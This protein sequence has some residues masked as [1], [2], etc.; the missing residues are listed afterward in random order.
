M[1]R[2]KKKQE[3]L[4]QSAKKLNSESTKNT[5][6]EPVDETDTSSN[7]NKDGID[8]D[9]DAPQKEKVKIFGIGRGKSARGAPKQKK[10]SPGELRIQKDIA[11]LD[12][13]KVAVVTFP[14][15]N[16]LT[17]FDVR[18]TADTGLWKGATYHF[19]FKIPPLYPHEPPKVQCMTK[20]YHPN[21]D[22]EGNVCLNILRE[23]WKPVLDINAVIY[24]LIYLFYEPNP[25]DPLNREAAEQFRTNPKQFERIVSRTLRGASYQGIH[26]DCLL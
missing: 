6:S 8:G 25:D 5:S 16:D 9:A 2:L 21:I 23:D 1:I 20:I 13:G 11:E 3:Q 18:I 14:N 17:V 4:K 24:G 10:R 12:G 15:P 7:S 19:T 22:L 26:F